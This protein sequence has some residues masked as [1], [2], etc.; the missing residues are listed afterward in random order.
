MHGTVSTDGIWHP[1][2]ALTGSDDEGV[3]CSGASHRT[4]HKSQRYTRLHFTPFIVSVDGLIGKEAKTVLKVLAA[5]TA[6]KAVK[7][8]SN[9]MRYVW[10][11]LRI[12][13][14]RATHVCLRDSRFPACK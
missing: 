11:R 4:S 3:M 2:L 7:T 5:R 10:S 9:V 13:I 12:A 6:T 1:S 14:V 8:Y